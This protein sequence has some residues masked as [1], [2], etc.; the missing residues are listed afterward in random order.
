VP[1]TDHGQSGGFRN[2]LLPICDVYLCHRLHDQ[3]S[4]LSTRQKSI[5]RFQWKNRY[6]LICSDAV[7]S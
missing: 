5:K 3:S 1:E 6:F 2:F 7:V 4:K